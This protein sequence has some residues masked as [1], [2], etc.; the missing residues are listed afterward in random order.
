[1]GSIVG[2]SGWIAASA[3][4]LPLDGK[5][6]RL[7]HPLRDVHAEQVPTRA[8]DDQRV[9]VPYCAP[10][11]DEMPITEIHDIFNFHAAPG[12]IHGAAAAPYER[13]ETAGMRQVG[14]I[15]LQ[16]DLPAVGAKAPVDFPRPSTQRQ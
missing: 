14:G 4:T 12:S 16:T 13:S 2:Y 8:F 15:L 7:D 1:L 9:P 10:K 5:A 6:T 3:R 11:L